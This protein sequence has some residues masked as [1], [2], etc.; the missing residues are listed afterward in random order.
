MA[1]LEQ[2]WDFVGISTAN[3]HEKLYDVELVKADL[4]NWFS[5]RK[6]ELDWNPEY[7]SII[8]ELIF[9]LQTER[10]RAEFEADVRTGVATD[11][12]LELLEL[13][14]SEIDHG[15][16]ASITAN[17]LKQNPPI[18]FQLNF[19]QRNFGSN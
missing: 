9:E 1:E 16:S 6:G 13:E 4:M 14:V 3:G 2:P 7:G 10:V 5:T 8:P 18:Q 12:R 15:Y 19:D 11:P 17:Y